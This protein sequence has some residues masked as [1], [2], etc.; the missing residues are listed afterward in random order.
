MVDLIQIILNKMKIFL[1]IVGLLFFIK[2]KSQTSITATISYNGNVASGTYKVY[3]DR[4]TNIPINNIRKSFIFVEGFDP[5]NLNNINIMYGL[6]DQHSLA[7]YLHTQGYD[8]IEGVAKVSTL[9]FV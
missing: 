1:I 7:Y 9:E 8:I 2:V 5:N 4:F 6:L 3:R